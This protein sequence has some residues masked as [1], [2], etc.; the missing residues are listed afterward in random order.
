MIE[1]NEYLENLISFKDKKLIKVIT[2]IRRCGKSTMFELYQSYLKENGVEEEQII[3]VNLEDGDYRGI[4]T[5]EKLYQYVES[6]LVKSNKNYVFLDEVQQVE[7]FQ[8]AVDWLYVKKNVDL[9]ITGSNAFLLSGELA[10]LLSGR[11]V[12]IKMLPLSFKEYI[13]AYPGNT[14]TGALYMNYLQNSSF[15]GTLELAR[16]QDI[17]V[18]LEG[19]YN[20]ILLKDIVTRKKISDP[21]MLQSVVEFMFDNIGN[22]CSSTKI[23]NAMTSSGRKISVPTVENYLSALCDSFILYKVGRYDIK[24]KQ[25]LATG[26]KYYA[27]DI[28]LR[29]FILGTKQADMGHILENIVYLELIRRGYEVHIG[30]VGDAEVDFIAIG[31]E[32]EEY[33]QVSQTVLEE[34]T[35]KRELSSLDAIKDHNPKYLLTMDYTPLTSY[36]GIKQVNVLEWLLKK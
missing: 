1:R 35:L 31:A 17:R 8:E 33:Y 34:Q 15:P 29:Y 16:K 19:I 18:Y 12:E 3:T 4:R 32:G 23:A 6:K 26:A 11:Y 30:K 7:N 5:S 36:N 13:S 22:M 25:Y 9:Y 21:F 2:G 20:T 14:N 24:G 27:A 10:T 28:G